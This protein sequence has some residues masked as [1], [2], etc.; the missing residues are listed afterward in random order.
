MPLVSG[1]YGFTITKPFTA[2][3]LQF[4][5][6]HTSFQDA[7]SAARDLNQYNLTAVVVAHDLPA[8][9]LFCLDTVLSFIE[10]LDVVITLPE[11]L[12]GDPFI[13]FDK[14][15]RIGRRHNGG[16]AVIGQ[17]TFFPGS[18]AQF[19]ELALARLMDA[20]YCESTGYRSL[21]FKVT[22]SF[23]QR[24]PFIEVSYFLMFSGL[25]TYIRKTLSGKQPSDTARLLGQRLRQLGFNVHGFSAGHPER[26]MDTYVR[27]RNALFHN[28]A[29]E[30][31]SKAGGISPTY[32]LNEF[33]GQFTILMS[34][35]VIK[36]TD[37]DD[38]HLNWDAWIDR[39]LFK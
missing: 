30:V 25:E 16:G 37:F 2:H 14:T 39:Q 21:F 1:I 26:S 33:F 9:L 38:G 6:A 19:V 35:V 36:A 15:Y 10:H 29:F 20:A 24:R 32:R 31:P 17:D 27:L 23:R 11:Q 4:L 28:G 34:L 7:E 3:G 13:Q 8:E 18:R 22:E 5:P 12:V